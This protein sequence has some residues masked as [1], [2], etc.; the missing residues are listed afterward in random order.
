MTAGEAPTLAAIRAELQELGDPVRATH[1][2]RFFK[3]GPGEYGEGDKFLGLTV[4]VMRTLVRKY[5]ALADDAALELLASPWHEERLV[6]LLLLVDGYKHGDERR[7]QKIHRAYLANARWINNW[8]LVDS[9]AEHVV[10]PHLDAGD[11]SLL[12]QLARSKNI[13]E[14]RIAIVST[15]HFI[16]RNEFRPTLRI[17]TILLG[18]SHDLIHKAV[19]WMLREVGK[20]DRKTLDAFLKKHYRQLPRTMLRYAIERHPER[21]RKRYLA[22]SV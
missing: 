14:R 18:D 17:A 20:R 16:K 3:T 4:P 1:S 11:I 22:G 12:E 10:G 7:R 8:D 21:T 6:A 5:R 15:F 19:G 2:L 13:W 9:S